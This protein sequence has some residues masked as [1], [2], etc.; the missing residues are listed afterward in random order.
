MKPN[1]ENQL[2]PE[3]APITEE[4]ADLAFDIVEPFEVI[5]DAIST[6]VDNI[7]S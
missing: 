6:I 2:P 3:P 1:D 7:T 4:L 5:G